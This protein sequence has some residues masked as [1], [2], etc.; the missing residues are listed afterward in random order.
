MRVL[1]G[2]QGRKKEVG[3]QMGVWC[4]GLLSLEL[5]RSRGCSCRLSSAARSRQERGEKIVN[6]FNEG[7]HPNEV[8]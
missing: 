2:G 6:F 5:G 8:V 4:V 1:A 3:S 7:L